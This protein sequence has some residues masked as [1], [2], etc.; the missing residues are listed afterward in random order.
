MSTNNIKFLELLDISGVDYVNEHTELLTGEII[1][2]VL[3][4]NSSIWNI[5]LL[6][7]NILPI[8][9][10]ICLTQRIREYIL[11]SKIPSS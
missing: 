3:I 9:T 6:F 1:K 10:V 7:D 11:S 2:V 4:N 8:K 5:H